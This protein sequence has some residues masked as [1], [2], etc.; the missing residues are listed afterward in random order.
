METSSF[1]HR[2]CFRILAA[3]SK[4]NSL[5]VMRLQVC[6]QAGLVQWAIIVCMAKQ[7]RKVCNGCVP[8]R[9]CGQQG[10]HFI[11]FNSQQLPVP[12]TFAGRLMRGRRRSTLH[13]ATA[14]WRDAQTN[15]STASTCQ[16]SQHGRMRYSR[17]L[18]G[19]G[20]VAMLARPTLWGP[21]QDDAN[22]C[23]RSNEKCKSRVTQLLILIRGIKMPR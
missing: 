5:G 2:L 3:I 16:Q 9:D 8:M 22:I 11:H 23:A 21:I 14:D 13:R 12:N 20:C 1:C 10:Y 18:A 4:P 19:T 7:T 15:W 17:Q 6:Q